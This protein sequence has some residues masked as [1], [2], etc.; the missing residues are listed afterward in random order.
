M[1]LISTNEIQRP[2]RSRR[3]ERGN[4]RIILL[5]LLCFCLGLTASAILRHR[6]AQPVALPEPPLELT[7]GTKAVLTRL[8]APVTIRFYSI[9]DPSAPQSQNAYAIRVNRLL[10]AY[11]RQAN[12]KIQLARYTDPANA[13]AAIADGIHGFDLDKGGGCYLGLALSY[14]DKKEAQDRLSPEWEAALESDVSRA[15][16]R[17]TET[18]TISQQAAGVRAPD[19][20][21]VEQVKRLIPNSATISTEEGSQILRQSALKEYSQ[22]VNDMQVQVRE[23][24]RQLEQAQ[25]TGS[26]ADQESAVKR[27]QELQAAQSEKLKKIAFKSQAQI[28]AFQQLKAGAN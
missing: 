23:A 28:A 25:N 12:G 2:R 1:R 19:T 11:Q 4:I 16:L 9:L 8:K 17:L 18:T 13:N 27:L 26:A 22:A 6:K 14:S 20:G 3:A 10:E 7:D 5:G 24:Q 21:V 15:I